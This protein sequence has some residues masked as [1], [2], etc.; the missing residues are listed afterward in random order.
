LPERTFIPEIEGTGST[1]NPYV[2]FGQPTIWPRGYPLDRVKEIA[3]NISES[4][5]IIASIQQVISIF[6]LSFMLN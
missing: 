4:K 5:P 6:F 2:Y 1:V 3:I